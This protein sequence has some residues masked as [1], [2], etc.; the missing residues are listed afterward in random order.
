M[1]AARVKDGLVL[2]IM[3]VMMMIAVMMVIMVV[4]MVVVMVM[5]LIFM[6]TNCFFNFTCNLFMILEMCHRIVM[7]IIV[8]TAAHCVETAQEGAK[9][10]N[11]NVGRRHL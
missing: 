7:M 4:M 8:L 10:T 9:K 1:E 6:S 3:V 2:V 11:N 5:V